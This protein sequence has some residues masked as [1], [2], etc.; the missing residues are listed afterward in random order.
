MAETLNEDCILH[1]IKHLDLQHIIY[2]AHTNQRFKD[3]EL[4]RQ[5]RI[6]PSTIG[7]INLLNF[8]YMLHIFGSKFYELSLSLNVFPSTFGL[9]SGRTKQQIL[10][11]IC[12]HTSSVGRINLYDFNFDESE[13]NEFVGKV[14]ETLRARGIEVNLRKSRSLTNKLKFQFP[15]SG[16]YFQNCV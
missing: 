6:F 3:M 5:L 9:Y 13:M 16:K 10:D 11:L 15:T 4:L 8:R 12:N 14:L 2:L 7:P 1:V